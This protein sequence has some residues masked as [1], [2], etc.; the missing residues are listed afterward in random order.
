MN[1]PSRLLRSASTLIAGLL[2]P[3]G[4]D[5]ETSDDPAQLEAKATQEA[6]LEG[7]NTAG[8]ASGDRWQR[9]AVCADW[10]TVELTGGM[11]G[12]TWEGTIPDCAEE[13]QVYADMC[14]DGEVP[15][16]PWWVS[17]G[18]ADGS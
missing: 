16:A 3:F 14:G 13:L 10:I 8:Y 6:A 11:F 12:G 15:L 18:K 7:A 5:V 1:S 2:L 17:R 9:H 4:I